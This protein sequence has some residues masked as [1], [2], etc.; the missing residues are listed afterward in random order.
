MKK[1]KRITAG[2]AIVV[3]A[4]GMSQC[5]KKNNDTPPPPPPAAK[6]VSLRADATQGNYLVDTNGHALY[7]FANDADGR[8]N[9][10]GACA[11]S[12]P[13]Y[14]GGSLSTDQLGAGLDLA[15]FGST[16]SSTGGTQL[17]YKGWP[18]YLF[19]PSG[20]AEPAG[21]ISGDGTGGT[22]FVGKPDYSI[23]LANWQLVGKDG[24]NY[25][26]DYIS[27]DGKTIYFTDGR[28]H[29]LY[30]FL[31]DSANH[32]RYTSADFTNNAVWPI[33]ETTNSLSFP[34]VLDKTLFTSTPVS[35]RSQL[36]YKGWP[37][38]YFGADSSVRA[39]TRGITVGSPA[40]TA[41]FVWPVAIQGFSPAPHL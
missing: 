37:L 31:A 30:S 35:G 22:W 4:A 16:A 32:N 26:S 5:S 41:G 29:T 40:G 12:W 8:N 3:L 7:F 2:V 6:L 13:A 24:N 1:V 28:G 36:S 33:Y 10:S 21:A 27:G 25:K 9:C 20:T 11:Q 23:M 39:R 34:S 17:T 19:T 14:E 15:D 18:L 38:Y